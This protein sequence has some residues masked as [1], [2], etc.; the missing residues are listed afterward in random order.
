M[1]LER[2]TGAFILNK[3]VSESGQQAD[4]SQQEVSKAESQHSLSVVLNSTVMKTESAYMRT[5]LG[6]WDGE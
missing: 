6:I 2:L 3:R 1:Q 4:R 5:L